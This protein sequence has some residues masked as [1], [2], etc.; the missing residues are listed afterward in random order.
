[1]R[2]RVEPAQR[3]GTIAI[4]P[5]KSDSQRTTLAAALANGTSVITGLGESDDEL[6][7]LNTIT[8]LGAQVNKTANETTITGIPGFPAE[9]T[10][11]AGESGLGIRLT[12]MVCAAHEGTY[13]IHGEGSLATRPMHFF[14]ETLPL[15]GASCTTEN[16]T[17][18][19]RIQGP[20]KGGTAEVDGSLSSQFISGL[21]MALPL[22]KEKSM[23]NV[24][25]LNS[26]PYVEMTLKTLKAFGIQIEHKHLN[27]F[28]IPG[29]QTYKP[30]VYTIDA[31]WSSASCWL[32]AA[33]IGHDLTLTGL[34]M[35]SLQADKALLNFLLAANCRI[36]RAEDGIRIDGSARKAF[37]GDATDCPDLFPALV[38]LA[39]YCDGKSVIKGTSRLVHKESNRALALQAE[40]AKLG[41]QID[42]EDDVMVVHGTGRVAG[43]E[44]ISHHDHRIA[45]CMAV[46]G[47][48]AESPVTINDAE[49][50]SKS[51]PAF[52]EVLENLQQLAPTVQ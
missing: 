42:L 30:A 35:D 51:Y 38:T 47:L 8:R 36:E 10:L 23:L 3:K 21:L 46:A 15:F 49:A 2:K 52:W 41:V 6:A 16:G 39:A 22:A 20:M 45:M 4:P 31:D 32:V 17:V 37:E 12:A 33:A 25:Q 5:S 29:N 27:T 13:T 50:V 44:V 14:E 34:Q 19:L 26:G 24:P 9:A 7:M 1:M 40:Y 28:T 48:L 18:P 43:G 11:T